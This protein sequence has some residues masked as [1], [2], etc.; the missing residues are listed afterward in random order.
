MLVL[1]VG[2]DAVVREVAESRAAGRLAGLGGHSDL[3]DVS[4]GL[5]GWPF[6]AVLASGAVPRADVTGTLPFDR[7]EE[8]LG[9]AAGGGGPTDGTRGGLGALD[10]LD[11]LALTG[12]DGLL[13]VSGTLARA[14][15]DVPVELRFGVRVEA[16][17]LV[18]SPAALAVA[19]REV[20][21]SADGP[22]AGLAGGLL[23]ERR[24]DVA[25]AF[26]TVPGSTGSTDGDADHAVLRAA[27]VTGSGLR[28]TLSVA[29][30]PLG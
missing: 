11:G 29:D 22:L 2:A 26:G 4:V 19:G 17:E 18:L 9:E 8:V 7:V 25:E 30:V 6:V 10:A 15:L 21:A 12:R 3:E 27:S 1:L 5:G 16:G 24:I 23:D 14:R 20:P 28:L 13:V